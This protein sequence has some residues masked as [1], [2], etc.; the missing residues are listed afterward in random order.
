MKVVPQRNKFIQ[1]ILGNN[2]DLIHKDDTLKGI[3][4]DILQS[5]KI[6]VTNNEQLFKR[7]VEGV[8]E[9]ARIWRLMF[10]IFDRIHSF[11]RSQLIAAMDPDK[12]CI[13]KL[14][15]TKSSQCEWLFGPEAAE[16]FLSAR[17][18]ALEKKLE[19]QK[20]F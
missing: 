10:S 4:Q 3:K 15:N 8:P 14:E 19:D 18:H 17:V 1:E 16:L 13:N 20:I 12:T 2:S 7:R 6:I 9:L 5:M 11:R